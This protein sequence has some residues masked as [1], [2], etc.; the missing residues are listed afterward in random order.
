M[1]PNGHVSWSVPYK[2]G[3]L[4][5]RAFDRTRKTIATD[6]VQTTGA[7]A[8]LRLQAD[9]RTIVDDG[10]DVLP[11]AVSVV[12]TRGRVV[13]TA[14]NMVTFSVIG[15]AEIVGVGNGDPSDH[16]PDKA[17]RRRAFNGRCLALVGAGT[18]RGRIVVTA[19]GPGLKSAT[20]VIRSVAG[21]IAEVK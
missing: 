15:P 12:D 19:R 13:P 1:P 18:G 16:S 21:H 9:R 4:L 17:N 7:P 10:E 14:S 3:T 6:T 20:F 8:A 2:P 11:L 5:A